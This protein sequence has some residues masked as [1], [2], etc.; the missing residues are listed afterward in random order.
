MAILCPHCDLHFDDDDV[1]CPG[2][3]YDPY[4]EQNNPDLDPEEIEAYREDM[5]L[6]ERVAEE[7]RDHEAEHRAEQRAANFLYGFD[8]E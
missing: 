2:C 5:L 4:F 3:G 1:E 6:A 7:R 8:R